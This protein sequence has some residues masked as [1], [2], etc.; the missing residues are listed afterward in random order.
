MT[1]LPIPA[2]VGETRRQMHWS[3]SDLGR[4]VG[5]SLRTVQRWEA[6]RSYPSSKVFAELAKRVYS[7][8]AALAAQLAHAHGQT[9][10]GLGLVPKELIAPVAPPP[11]P[12]RPPAPKI[13]TA[14]VVDCIVCS[15]AEAAD[16]SPKAVRGLVLLTLRRA[17][18][19]GLD[20][21]AAVKEDGHAKA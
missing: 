19:L 20:I 2:L 9:L 6:S 10:A 7:R 17:H 15:V 18:E 3:Q 13:A 8:D 4:A 12:P 16:A 14:D 5:A 11:A 1:M 21:E